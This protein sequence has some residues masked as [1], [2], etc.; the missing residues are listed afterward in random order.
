MTIY[1][2]TSNPEVQDYIRGLRDDRIAISPPAR[3]GSLAALYAGREDAI[4]IID[5]CPPGERPLLHKEILAELSRGVRIIG[6][7]AAGAIRAAEM[8]P[9]GMEGVGLAFRLYRQGAITSDDEVDAVDGGVSLINVRAAA[10]MLRREG[11]L[12]RADAAR[13]VE[14]A[15]ALPWYERNWDS[16]LKRAALP[17]ARE[18]FQR[19]F[20]DVTAA[21]AKRA[22]EYVRH[23]GK[24][25]NHHFEF[26]DTLGY[27]EAH[28]FIPPPSVPPQPFN[29]NQVLAVA[30][31]VAAD[32]PQLFHRVAIRT[33]LL[34]DD[35]AA[36]TY[37][38]GCHLHGL[39]LEP[40]LNPHENEELQ[41][42][43]DLL[44]SRYGTSDSD[45][46]TALVELARRNG[47]IPTLN[48][49]AP[50]KSESKWLDESELKEWNP[51]ERA[52]HMITR[53]VRIAPF[54]INRKH[55]IL[56]LKRIGQFS[57]SLQQLEATV[58]F[59]RKLASRNEGHVAHLIRD[60]E[61]SS[62]FI[63]SWGGGNP[64]ARW[65]ERGYPG[66]TAMVESVRQ[67]YFIHRFSGARERWNLYAP[68]FTQPAKLRA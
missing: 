65:S 11:R 17:I 55:L 60:E 52:A 20:A 63:E 59:N 8:E 10:R 61:I 50:A 56:E 44:S 46:E 6:A 48:G 7:G 3:F 39:T 28:S 38:C 35:R 9:F 12:S 62:W 33:L 49:T 34:A 16:I 57:A 5:G 51:V 30:Q 23:T 26:A 2:M 21:D 64:I 53:A 68:S 25:Q 45:L 18:Q 31:A 15:R 27:H 4:I 32:F 22:L 37:W 14:S 58:A 43:D 66:Q 54:L 36:S 1:C 67:L 40:A 47:T 29:P 24:P 41:A 19:H 13:V 42:I